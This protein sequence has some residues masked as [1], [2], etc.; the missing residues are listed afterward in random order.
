MGAFS[1]LIGDTRGL[2]TAQ[3]GFQDPI[4]VGSN[5]PSDCQGPGISSASIHRKSRDIRVLDLT[6]LHE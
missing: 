2:G 1:A 4:P 3:G 5:T 6:Y